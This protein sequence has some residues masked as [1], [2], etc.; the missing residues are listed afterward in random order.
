M[1]RISNLMSVGRRS[2]MNAQTGLHTVSHNIANKETEGYSRQRTE[3][4]T[5][6]PIGKGKLR[7]GRGARAAVVR[8]V[9]NPFLEKQLAREMT[10]LNTSKGRQEGLSGLESIFNEQMVEGFSQSLTKFFN[11]F[12]ELSTNPES[13]PVRTL[14]KES[15]IA[16]QKNFQSMSSQLNDMSKSI[17]SQ[18]RLSAGELNGYMQ[19]FADLNQKIMEVEVSGGW[20]NDERDRRDLLLKKMGEILDIKSA[21][22][23]DG[24]VTVQTASDAIL[25]VGN[26]AAR[27]EAISTPAREGKSEGSMDLVFYHHDYADPLNITDRIKG[28]RLGGLLESRSGDLSA[29]Q[30]DVDSLA[31]ALAAEVNSY[32]K[33]G[34]N[35]YNQTGVLFFSPLD[36]KEG[37][38][39][40]LSVNSEVMADVGRIAAG[41]DPNRPGDNRVANAIGQLQY[42]KSVFP[43]G[44]SLSEFYQGL[45]GEI[46]VKANQVN[47]AVEAQDKIVKQL[48]HMRESISG[49]SLDE[50]AAKMIEMQKQFDASA[51]MIR[52]ADEILETVINLRRY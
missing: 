47:N 16:L 9:N 17:D 29:V 25:V 43:G 21:E 39:Q 52:T 10:D 27:V 36:G 48:D 22:G 1:S 6:T 45:V 31:Y 15:G 19:E 40:R 35:A 38:A 11:A 7:I 51:R 20:A 50:E 14:V 33:Q 49:V 24:T 26:T 18:L 41:A 30:E 12:R 44:L 5:S 37:A 23:D 4:V 3:T 32:H 42:Q 8:R 46:G 28:G 13:M 2:M 34:Y